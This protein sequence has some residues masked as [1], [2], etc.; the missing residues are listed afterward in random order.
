MSTY[1]PG[2]VAMIRDNSTPDG[3]EWRAVKDDKGWFGTDPGMGWVSDADVTDVRPLVVLELDAY[4]NPAELLRLIAN[5]DVVNA[6]RSLLLN[7]A[8][9]IEAQV[10]PPHIPEPTEPLSEVQASTQGCERR[11]FVRGFAATSGR[12]RWVDGVAGYGWDEL[13]DPT[14]VREG[15]T[16]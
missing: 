1:A 6:K 8:D 7:I 11:R 14:L 4:A 10:K 12:V 5:E 16:R 13:I 9:Q 3:S 2:T 15:V